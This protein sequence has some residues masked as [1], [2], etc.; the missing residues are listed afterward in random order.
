MKKKA[1]VTKAAGT[2][3]P[4]ACDRR[5]KQPPTVAAAAIRNSTTESNPAAIAILLLLRISSEITREGGISEYRAS[6]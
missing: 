5:S 2:S 4:L 1:P 6:A 3:Q